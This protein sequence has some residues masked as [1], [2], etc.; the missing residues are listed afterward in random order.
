M[1]KRITLLTAT[2]FLLAAL[3][4]GCAGAG[5]AESTSA[6]PLWKAGT[7]AD[8]TVVISDLHL[9]IYDSF[10]EDVANRP[11]LVHFLKQLQATSDVKELVIAGDFLDEWYL[12]MD[13]PSY[14]SS[15]L[16]YRRVI[17]N[18]QDVFDALKGVM[19]SGITLV[20]V[21]GNHD[22]LLASGVLDQTLPGIVQ[23]RDVEGLGTYY[24]GT[25]DNIAIEHGHRY[26]AFSAPDTLTNAVLTGNGKTILPPGYFYARYAASWVTEGRPAVEKNYPV[27]TAVPDPADADQTNAYL[28]YRVLAAELGRMTPTEAFDAK[29]FNLKIGGFAA[30]YSVEDFYPVLQADGTISAP[31]LFQNFQR[32]WEERQDLNQVAVKVDFKQ[33]VL[34]AL[35]YSFLQSQAETQYLDNPDRQVDV[36]VFGHSHIPQYLARSDGKIYI[37]DGT[38]VD[39]NTSDPQGTSR[40]FAVITQGDA[41]TAALYQYD[42]D[43]GAAD[44]SAAMTR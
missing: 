20:Y 28:Y 16:F 38:W 15:N 14:A 6:A 44:I 18:N 3:L 23:A 37:N 21:P 42:A 30:A 29:C 8:K 2:L 27:I 31:T 25:D 5:T 24:T 33:S 17:A 11:Q 7:T 40:T 22:M 10:A 39:N 35:G 1:H 41:P 32:T 4:T 19:Q 36:V 34:G 43:R 12:P 13:Y 9:G 26:D